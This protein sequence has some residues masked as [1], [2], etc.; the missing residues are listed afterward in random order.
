MT[1]DGGP[2]ADPPTGR[3]RGSYREGVPTRRST[4][5][6][7]IAARIAVFAGIPV[8]LAGA[9]CS[10]GA[11]PPAPRPTGEVRAELGAPTPGAG[12]TAVLDVTQSVI[13]GAL[14]DRLALPT[15]TWR[16]R[17]WV[18]A[19]DAWRLEVQGDGHDWQLAREGDVLRLYSSASQTA[20]TLGIDRVPDG[21]AAVG[22][23]D[24][25]AAEPVVVADRPAYRIVYRPRGTGLL[26]RT[27]AVAVDAQTG[28]PLEVRLGAI[29][30]QEPVL[31]MIATR[32]STA[33]VPAA[34]V[35]VRAPRNGTTVPLD[36]LIAA[37]QAGAGVQVVGTGWARALRLPL[38]ADG[39]GGV[40]DAL[41]GARDAS[42]PE[43]RG[44]AT[45]LLSALVRGRVLLVGPVTPATLEA[46][47]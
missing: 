18:R 38:G 10:G 28:V 17:M 5:H 7:R 23:V 29:G 31:H 43:R 39:A 27:I 42:A 14:R 33:P 32:V 1:P 6:P 36:L 21:L 37:G 46:L 11:A 19:R 9:G 35:R 41:G 16:G 45:P 30:Q 34:R 3:P 13:P 24:V 40:L 25:G 15:G 22:P 4:A 2:A 47:R 44:V 12:F 26:V 20:Y 8:A